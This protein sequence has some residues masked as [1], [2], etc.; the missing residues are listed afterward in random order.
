V[1]WAARGCSHSPFPRGCS[2]SPFPAT[3]YPPQGGKRA[4]GGR[5][6]SAGQQIMGQVQSLTAPFSFPRTLL[7]D[8]SNYLI[9]CSRAALSSHPG[10]QESEDPPSERP[11]RC[12]PQTLPPPH[13][14]LPTAHPRNRPPP[15]AHRQPP[16][17]NRQPPTAH[18]PPP[19]AAGAGLQVGRPPLLPGG[20]PGGQRQRLLRRGAARRAR[21]HQVTGCAA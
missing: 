10:L 1:G 6:F 20:G 11:S 19:T 18:R 9:L 15:T 13:C 3:P 2:H 4:G 17:A 8:S 14:P 7:Q 21:P 5:R 16:T 12:P